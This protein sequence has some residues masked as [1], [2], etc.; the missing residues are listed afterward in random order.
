[1]SY[2]RLQLI[3][4][5][6]I[7][8]ISL[9]I[10]T[11]PSITELIHASN[12]QWVK[13]LTLSTNEEVRG[14][15][16]NQE[17]DLAYVSTYY[18]HTTLESINV[19]DILTGD[20]LNVIPNAQCPSLS[21][22]GSIVAYLESTERQKNVVVS[23]IEADGSVLGHI[24]I[25]GVEQCPAISYD[26]TKLSYT[27]FE[28]GIGNNYNSIYLT[29]IVETTSINN[30][31]TLSSSEEILVIKDSDCQECHIIDYQL[32]DE[33]GE[34]MIYN[35]Y[36]E[37]DDSVETSIVLA[38]T[39]G[40][41]IPGI[42]AK[43]ESDYVSRIVNDIVYKYVDVPSGSFSSNGSIVAFH[44]G[45]TYTEG[46]SENE[47][48]VLAPSSPL[49]DPVRVTTSRDGRN[50]HTPLISR[51]GRTIVYWSDNDINL[52]IYGGSGK[53]ITSTLIKQALID[54]AHGLTS[55]GSVIVSNNNSVTNQ[56]DL[57]QDFSYN[58]SGFNL[59]SF[60]GYDTIAYPVTKQKIVITKL[61][62]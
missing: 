2:T 62:P 6:I 10:F 57:G 43:P 46:G 26:G 58:R 21:D 56:T 45:K 14:I 41:K 54:P 38:D 15:E 34:T 52:A 20:L 36:I 29:D 23:S 1:M 39:A 11:V 30:Y 42:I 13:E 16:L 33:K 5:Y 37:N 9:S 59:L 31:S 44:D 24:L 60:D 7:Y 27:K 17:T 22:D 8:L 3:H 51:D 28:E 25:E 47:I 19:F 4:I 40:N 61:L 18:N 50:D 55:Y 48:F 49:D 53:W 35:R 32:S 12:L